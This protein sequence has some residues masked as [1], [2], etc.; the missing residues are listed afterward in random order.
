MN[1]EGKAPPE[2]MRDYRIEAKLRE[3]PDLHRLAQLF[4]TM[5]LARTQAD[6]HRESGSGQ[7]PGDP[8]ES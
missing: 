4:V 2:R 6:Q 8:V 7:N 5:A 3:A 1:E